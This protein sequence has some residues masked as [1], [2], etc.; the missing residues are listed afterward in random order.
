MDK[1]EKEAIIEQDKKNG[2][3][4]DAI[5]E[6]SNNENKEYFNRRTDRYTDIRE[7]FALVTNWMPPYYRLRYVA[8]SNLDETIKNDVIRKYK[9]LFGAYADFQEI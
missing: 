7:C 9:E 3:I 4:F 1:I 6:Q 8:Q 5:L 2:V